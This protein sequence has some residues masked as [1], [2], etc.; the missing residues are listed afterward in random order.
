MS[1]SQ[2]D[3]GSTSPWLS[4]PAS[5]VNELAPFTSRFD[6]EDLCLSQAGGQTFHLF[7]LNKSPTSPQLLMFDGT[8]SKPVLE[9]DY[10]PIAFCMLW[11]DRLETSKATAQIPAI[12]IASQS[13]IHIYHR[14]QLIHCVALP[15][16]SLDPL[17]TQIWQRLV[18]NP[19]SSDAI[20]QELES[21]RKGG[22]HSISQKTHHVLSLVPDKRAAFIES[23]KN[24]LGTIAPHVSFLSTIKKRETVDG[25]H[26][27]VLVVG[28]LESVIY[29]INPPKF[30]I[31]E[32]V[33]LN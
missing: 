15:S 9:L 17:E 22:L 24:V 6:V 21:L 18:D 1:S 23:M 14:F 31:I 3:S 27:S 8:Q 13:A 29:L 25:Y 5:H 33:S 32:K 12:A 10:A 28:T 4:L 11:L 16:F 2:K 7:I 26:S 20:I 19:D 30:E